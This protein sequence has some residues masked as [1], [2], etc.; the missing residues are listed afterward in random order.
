MIENQTKKTVI[1]KNFSKKSAFAKIKGL[2]GKKTAQ[3]MV[4]NTRFGIH[5][6]FLQFPIDVI[7]LDRKN[8][9]VKLKKGLKPN[10][11]FFWNIK[12]ETVIE[13]PDKALEKSKTEKGDIIVLPEVF[14]NT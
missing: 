13:L 2:I 3:A 5:T 8:Q 9:V 7:I 1:A 12:F 11:I 10:R 4:F 14:R 6:F